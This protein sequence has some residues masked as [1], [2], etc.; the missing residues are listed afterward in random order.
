MGKQ[1]RLTIIVHRL[2]NLKMPT[3]AGPLQSTMV[4]R[5]V[6]TSACSRTTRMGHF[7]KPSRT[8]VLSLSITMKTNLRTLFTR[9]L[10][11]FNELLASISYCSSSRSEFMNRITTKACRQ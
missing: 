7:E 6:Y 10:M 11:L 5:S 3:M 2:M 4:E 8:K 9:L 1:A